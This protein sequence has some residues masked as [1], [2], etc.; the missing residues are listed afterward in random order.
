MSC[1]VCEIVLLYREYRGA[2]VTWFNEQLISEI[3]DTLNRHKTPLHIAIAAEVR[4]DSLYLLD[5]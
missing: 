1:G 3:D 2:G 4:G 5:I